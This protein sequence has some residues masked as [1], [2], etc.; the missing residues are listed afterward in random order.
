MTP[1]EAVPVFASEHEVNDEAALRALIGDEVPGLAEKNIDRLDSFAIDFIA[2]SPF[3]VLATADRDGAMDASPKGDAPGFVHVLDER[4]LLVP[5]RAGN[6]LAYGHLNVL[7]NPRV[8]L[9]FVI[10]GTR[11]T[12]RVNG[13]ATLHA[14]PEWLERLAAA[15]GKPAKVIIKVQVSEVFFHCAKAFIRSKLWQPEQWGEPHKVSFGDI[16][17]ARRAAPAEV[18]AQIDA[19]VE[20]DYEN[21]L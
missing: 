16:F 18:A 15:D 1:G 7:A 6:K 19:A 17:A 2:R 3:L 20:Q 11:E 4:T 10:P 14:D 12:L 13:T 9:I 8:G 21:N 5:D